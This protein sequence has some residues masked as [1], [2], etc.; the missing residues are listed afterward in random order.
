M[1]DHHLL[2]EIEFEFVG[3]NGVIYQRIGFQVDV[4]PVVGEVI[5]VAK[6]GI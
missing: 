5:F 4:I 2:S 3:K 6:V 1:L